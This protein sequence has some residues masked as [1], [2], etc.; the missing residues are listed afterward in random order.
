MNSQNSFSAFFS[1]FFCHL[2]DRLRPAYGP[3]D[4]HDRRGG[5]LFGDLALQLDL[6][7]VQHGAVPMLGASQFASPRDCRRQRSSDVQRSD[8]ARRKTP[9]TDISVGATAKNTTGLSER[10]C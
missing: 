5:G 10:R 3:A 1:L 4:G 8:S 2:S 7:A 9:L 6:P